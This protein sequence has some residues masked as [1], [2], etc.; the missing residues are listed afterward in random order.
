MRVV[1]VAVTVCLAGAAAVPATASADEQ[2]RA[3][4]LALRAAYGLSGEAGRDAALA[5]VAERVAR[6]GAVPA[7][8]LPLRVTASPESFGAATTPDLCGCQ[9]EPDV[10]PSDAYAAASGRPAAESGFWAGAW[11][12]AADGAT[13]ARDLRDTGLAL[14]LLDPRLT[15]LEVAVGE[16]RIV[17]AGRLDRSRPWPAVSPVLAPGERFV[18]EGADRAP[19]LLTGPTAVGR[20][21]RLQFRERG[22]WRTHYSC[23]CGLYL[24]ARSGAGLVVVTVPLAWD[25][26]YRVSWTGSPPGELLTGPRPKLR[27]RFAGGWP[28]RDRAFVERTIKKTNP[29]IRRLIEAVAPS[30]RFRRYRSQ[31]SSYYGNGT[32][33][34]GTGHLQRKRAHVLIHEIG[35]AV[36]SLIT[37]SRADRSISR[38]LK[39]LPRYRSCFRYQ[40]G[41]L[42]FHE[43]VA[44]QFAYAGIV[45]RGFQSFYQVPRFASRSRLARIFGAIVPTPAP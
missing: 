21:I 10:Q 3:A 2:A 34:V 45:D 33:Y 22:R 28:R 40:G 44:E 19:L 8:R 24:S 5:Q 1:G 36:A 4:A 11:G 20:T 38:A 30:I 13:L 17:I 43:I 39:R 42:G 35:H 15:A 25:A 7:G 29:T 27:L 32:V 14:V 9:I 23:D 26:R 31:F 16:G 18:P 37:D 6:E 41:C 12:S